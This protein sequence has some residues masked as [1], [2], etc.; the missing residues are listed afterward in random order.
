MKVM[1]R[2]VRAEYAYLAGTEQFVG[3]SYFRGRLCLVM[4]YV[5]GGDLRR[6]LDR[7]AN[8]TWGPRYHTL[9]L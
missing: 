8:W 5:G 6:H 3:A 4:E 2:W 7:H 1:Q 9:C